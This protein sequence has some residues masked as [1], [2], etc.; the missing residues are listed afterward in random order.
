MPVP[1]CEIPATTSP[2]RTRAFRRGFE[3]GKRVRESSRVL[4]VFIDDQRHAL[5]AGFLLVRR[6]SRWTSTP[7]V[8][9]SFGDAARYSVNVGRV[10]RFSS[11]GHRAAVLSGYRYHA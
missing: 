10:L 6:D 1:G 3:G 4:P 7:F 5:E 11:R 9:V 2:G 8:I